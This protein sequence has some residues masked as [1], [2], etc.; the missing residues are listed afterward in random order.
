MK[1][2]LLLVIV[3]CL[4]AT[5]LVFFGSL[6]GR[7]K[8]SA[9]GS[10]EKSPNVINIGVYE[11]LTGD[12][13]RGGLTEALALRYANHVTPT[14]DVGG[15]TYEIKLVEADNA[16][17]V[18][19]SAKA[20]QSLV[21][22][23][24]CVVLGSYGAKATAAGLPEFEAAKLPTI[25][26]SCS[27]QTAT[28]SSTAYFRMCSTDDFQSGVMANLAHGMGL[29]KAAVL[30]QTGDDYS[31]DAGKIFIKAF[32]KL[33]GEVVEASFQLG[34]Q[35]FRSLASQL[36]AQ[37]V[38]FVYM[39]S[40]ASEAEYFLK[41]ARAEGLTCPIFGPESWDSP[42]LLSDVSFDFRDVY[43]ASGFNS[44]MDADPVAAEFSDRYSRWL[45]KDS[46][47]IKE[48]GGNDYC[49]TSASAA[50]DAYMLV[51]DAIKTADSKDPQAITEAIR[52]ISYKGI[53]GDISFSET[54]EALKK[55]AF[56]KTID[57]NAQQFKVLQTSIG[58]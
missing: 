14:V 45:N 24:V 52:K 2:V 15:V 5:M 19:G 12:N 56:I 28:Q 20:A 53:S 33:D 1:K 51:V 17:D 13:A 50:Y 6:G 9:L 16:S 58:S 37:D 41:Q 47:R 39:L 11:P 34:Q 27:S 57:P 22:S 18:S 8:I 36:A 49:S 32:E 7:D 23:K 3:F 55:Q 10:T 54:G 31:K 35:N 42:L 43:I 4:I 48:N 25:G 46:E 44:G 26:I 38:D 40:G 30:T 21:S 29:K